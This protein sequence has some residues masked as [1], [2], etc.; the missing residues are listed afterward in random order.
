MTTSVIGLEL[1]AAVGRGNFEHLQ[2]MIAG[3]QPSSLPIR[4][5]AICYRK[6]AAGARR[7]KHS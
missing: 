5:I 4:L 7:A 2:R 1:K 6:Q 3:A